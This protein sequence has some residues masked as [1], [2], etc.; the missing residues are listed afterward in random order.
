METAFRTHFDDVRIH[1]GPEAA[2]LGALAFTTGSQIYFAPGQYQPT[3]PHG[4]RLLGHELAHVVQQKSGR[5]RHPTGHGVAIVQDPVL[6]AEADRMG[7]LASTGSA[8]Q[9]KM[10]DGPATETLAPVSGQSDIFRFGHVVIP[11]NRRFI[12]LSTKEDAEV[13]RSV[14][15]GPHIDLAGKDFIEN[16]DCSYD[17]PGIT[18]EIRTAA[19]KIPNTGNVLVNCLN[20]RSRSAA[21]V[22]AFFLMRRRYTWRSAK[23][24]VQRF[25]DAH[26]TNR[27]LADREERFSGCFDK[28]V[29]DLGLNTNSVAPMPGGHEIEESVRFRNQFYAQLNHALRRRLAYGIANFP[30]YRPAR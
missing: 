29:S 30:G 26:R 19:M 23:A 24:R 10:A 17:L 8:V 21:A 4:L 22:I 3:T 9:A 6:E 7:I 5:V 28:L 27:I 14:L 15:H 11:D 1:I 18:E 25:Y 20:G 2:S 12:I 16:V 13:I